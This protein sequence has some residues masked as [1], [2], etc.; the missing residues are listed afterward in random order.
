M[1]IECEFLGTGTSYG[2]PAIGCP[3]DVCTSENPKNKRLRSS[4]VITVTPDDGKVRRFLIDATPDLRYQAL[5]AGFK[6]IDALLLTHEHADHTQGLDDTRAFYWHN[7]KR[8]IP[9]FCYPETLRALEM[10]FQYMFDR[11]NGYRGATSFQPQVIDDELFVA[12]GI[13]IL[14]IPL[15]HGGMRVAAFRIGDFAYITDTNQVPPSSI[16]KL[17]GVKLL[18][19]DALRRAPHATHMSLPESL[20][21]CRELGVEQAY[22]THINHDLE[23]ETISAELPAFANLGYDTLR[24]AIDNGRCEVAG[25]R[26]RNH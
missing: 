14:P 10:R 5:R 16:E 7:G 12:A 1:R 21:V 9:L 19:M 22:F 3:C 8:D 26:L 25:D 6:T 18:V 24:V 11:E 13:E 15:V 20:A 4:V 17:R 23:H 2:V